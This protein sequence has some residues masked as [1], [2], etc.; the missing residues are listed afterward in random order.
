MMGLGWDKGM[1][2]SKN[3]GALSRSFKQ[4][5]GLAPEEDDQLDDWYGQAN[6]HQWTEPG[7]FHHCVP[8][9]D[10]SRNQCFSIH[11]I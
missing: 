5:G 3:D 1:G 8:Y 7:S 9:E 4:E 11:V 6:G 2:M 10:A